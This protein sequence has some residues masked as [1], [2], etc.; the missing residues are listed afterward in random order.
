MFDNILLVFVIDVNIILGWYINLFV[1]IVCIVDVRIM[2]I[3]MDFI[4]VDL[5]EVLD[6]VNSIFCDSEKLLVIVFV[7]SGCVNLEN[8]MLLFELL[9][10]GLV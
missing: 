4:N 8:I 2:F 1:V 10:C 5:F 3:V 9:I 6:L 7:M